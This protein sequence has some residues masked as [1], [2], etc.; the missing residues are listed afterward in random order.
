MKKFL[1]VLFVLILLFGWGWESMPAFAAPTDEI[2][3]VQGELDKDL[4]CI[5]CEKLGK[6]WNAEF[7]V[8]ACGPCTVERNGKCEPC[9]PSQECVEGICMD[10]LPD[11]PPTTVLV[12]PEI[13][14]TEEV[15]V[16]VGEGQVILVDPVDIDGLVVD[17]DAGCDPGIISTA[18]EISLDDFDLTSIGVGIVGGAIT[19]IAAQSVLNNFQSSNINNNMQIL[20][21]TGKKL[22]DTDRK[23]RDR[24]KELEGKKNLTPKEKQ[25]L[26]ILKNLGVKNRG[27][28]NR[29]RDKQRQL[30]GQRQKN[31][32]NKKKLDNI[33]SRL[34]PADR[35][36]LDD[37]KKTLAGK[38]VAD[39]NKT[40]FANLKDKG[41]LKPPSDAQ[42]KLLQKQQESAKQKQV[43][44]QQR[45]RERQSQ[46]KGL[47]QRQE[48]KIQQQKAQQELK[49]RQQREQQE[50]K[51]RQQREQ[52]ERQKKQL[53]QQKQ[54][55]ELLKRRQLQEQQKREQQLKQQ[56]LQQQ[57]QREQQLRQQQ[58]QQQRQREQQLRER[59]LQQQRARERQLQQ[60]R[61][62]QQLRQQQLQREQQLRQQQLHQQREQ[63]LRQQQYQQQQQQRWQQQRQQQH[64]PPQQQYRPPQRNIPPPPPVHR[65]PPRNNPN[66][67]SNW[68][69]NNL[70]R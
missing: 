38:G 54:R 41:K 35:K 15:S 50:Q 36:K 4:N 19:S 25:E 31:L 55:E 12:D 34:N 42:K 52:Q 20:D 32:D 69:P 67:R 7:R 44:Q 64:R 21:K 22:S 23:I 49:L 58:L 40:R 66:D 29:I 60:Q 18:D 62:E 46:Q 9:S 28:K 56:Q 10:P 43:Q 24:I 5:P 47:K 14:S 13:P 63:Q 61:H 3:C 30:E 68:F 2:P 45:L 8:C 37:A 33:I 27:I 17:P 39:P 57:R 53:L 70:R 1:N 16:P 51:L 59:Q 65:N 48:Q 26:Q 11:L 6:V